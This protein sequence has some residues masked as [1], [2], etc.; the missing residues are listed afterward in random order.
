MI[1][2]DNRCRSLHRAILHRED[3]HEVY[4]RCTKTR[5]HVSRWHKGWLKKWNDDEE[6]GGIEWEEDE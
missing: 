2:D 3:G 1:E 5:E 6:D 4:L